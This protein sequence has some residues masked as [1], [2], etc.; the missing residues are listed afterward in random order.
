MHRGYRLI[1]L[2]ALENG[3][4][5]DKSYG[6]EVQVV[7]LCKT[8]TG[9]ELQNGSKQ[10]RMETHFE[11][12]YLNVAVVGAVVVL[13]VWLTVDE[14]IQSSV[15]IKGSLYSNPIMKMTVEQRSGVSPL[16][17]TATLLIRS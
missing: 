9:E 15:E 17:C 14:S 10:D 8:D 1:E 4:I 11:V 12:L 5:I 6:C 16:G 13:R 3:H 2:P 7:G